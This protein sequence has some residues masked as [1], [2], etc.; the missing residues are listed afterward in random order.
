LSRPGVH[1]FCRH[2]RQ[3][4]AWIGIVV[5]LAGVARFPSGSEAVPAQPD[6]P[7]FVWPS[8]AP[9]RVPS[10][11]HATRLATDFRIAL[12]P[13]SHG[14]DPIRD[15]RRIARAGR[16]HISQETLSAADGQEEALLVP[17]DGDR[18]AIC[19]DPTPPGGWSHVRPA[20]RRDVRRHRYR[21][22]VAH[23]I[24]HTFF[25]DRTAGRPRRRLD[26]SQ[27]EEL[28]CDEFARA[29]LLPARAAQRRRPNP[30]SILSLHRDYDVSVEVAARAVA[31]SRGDLE[32]AVWYESPEQGW[33]LQW[34]NVGPGRTEHI[35]GCAEVNRERGQAIAVCSRAG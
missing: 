12:L 23:E 3:N 13:R 28:F 8:F 18:F 26:G 17:L 9:L 6:A 11:S 19:V 4:Y 24:A 16:F 27:D 1:V 22:R 34:S 30:S 21:F 7:P 10:S 29:L 20:L 32:V 15:F 2:G 25:Y 35:R 14:A 5:G 33:L 31:G